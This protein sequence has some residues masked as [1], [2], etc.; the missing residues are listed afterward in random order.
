MTSAKVSI[1]NVQIATCRVGSI[2]FDDLVGP[3]RYK[4]MAYWRQRG[5]FVARVITGRSYPQIGRAFGDRDHT[6]ALFATRKMAV[7]CMFNEDAAREVTLIARYAQE[8]ADEQE[9]VRL[10][11]LAKMAAAQANPAKVNPDALRS[12][13]ELVAWNGIGGV[14]A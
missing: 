1:N 2:K 9:A 5:M 13:S 7:R 8:L 11:R 3:R 12:E 6:T 14:A 10:A 4:D